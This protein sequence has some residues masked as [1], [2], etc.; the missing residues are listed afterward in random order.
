[1]YA[2][3]CAHEMLAICDA[4]CFLFQVALSPNDQNLIFEI[5][6]VP[7]SRACMYWEPRTTQ[8]PKEQS[9]HVLGNQNYAK[10]QGTSQELDVGSNTSKMN[11]Q[12]NRAN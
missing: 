12:K 1:M 3:L 5:R 8:S 11:V 2:D 7:R 10:S 9:V 4:V 6:K